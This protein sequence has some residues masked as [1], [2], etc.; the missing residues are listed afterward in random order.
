MDR[1]YAALLQLRCCRSFEME[2]ITSGHFRA[3]TNHIRNDFFKVWKHEDLISNVST[4]KQKKGVPAILTIWRSV[5]DD[6]NRNRK[7]FFV[8]ITSF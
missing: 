1:R 2:G 3:L 5:W 8:F 4:Q 7:Y 6:Y